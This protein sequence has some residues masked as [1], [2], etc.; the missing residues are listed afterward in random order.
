[1]IYKNLLIAQAKEISQLLNEYIISH[2]KMLQS[3]GTFKSL[4]KNVDFLTIHKDIEEVKAN[5]EKKTRELKEI[6]D[7]YYG[8]L[9]DVS[10][11]FFDALE[12][13]FNSLFEAVK[14]LSILSFRLYE[15]SRGIIGNKQKLSWSEYSQLTKEYDKKVKG[16]FDLGGKLNQAYQAL[17]SEPNDFIDEDENAKIKTIESIYKENSS[18]FGENA[19]NPQVQQRKRRI[20]QIIDQ[21]EKRILFLL[22]GRQKEQLTENERKI[23]DI[24]VRSSMYDPRRPDVG[25]GNK[26]MVEKGFE[27][28]AKL[29]KMSEEEF[30]TS[31]YTLE[32]IDTIGYGMKINNLPIDNS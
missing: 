7:E 2:D 26:E 20:Q 17:E 31:S 21:Y 15:T 3:A 11:E 12:S 27:I 1:M 9:A 28:G 16:Y 30:L 13:Y 32:W 6:K 19:V 10:M 4:F 24:L 23:Y 29:D 5:F 18:L 8:S 22:N 14:Q 25:F